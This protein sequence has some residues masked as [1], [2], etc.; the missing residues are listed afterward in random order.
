MLGEI[1]DER[2]AESGEVAVESF[3]GFGSD[4]QEGAVVVGIL[5]LTR[6]VTGGRV[7]RQTPPASLTLTV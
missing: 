2:A 4:E 6:T 5:P 7:N 3:R 1:E